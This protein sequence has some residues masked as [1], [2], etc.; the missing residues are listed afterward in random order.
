QGRRALRTER[1]QQNPVEPRRTQENPGEPRRTQQNLISG[2]V[3]FVALKGVPMRLNGLP[4]FAWSSMAAVSVLV[5]G[6]LSLVAQ[7][8]PPAPPRTARPPAAAPTGTPIKV[9]FIGTDEE[10]PHNPSKMFP[11]LA[12]PLA[13]RG[14]QLTYAGT[15]TKVLDASKLGYYDA[16]MI[17]GDRISL[18]ATQQQ[19]IDTFVAAGHGVVALHN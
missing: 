13:R 19:A 12:A 14:I 8:N 4:R 1:T 11:L 7:P 17:Y 18:S 6:C 3:I 5:L 10:T 15:P 16:V 9:L 2:G